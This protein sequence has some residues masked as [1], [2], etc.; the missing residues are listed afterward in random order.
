MDVDEDKVIFVKMYRFVSDGPSAYPDWSRLIQK[1]VDLE[2]TTDARKGIHGV[3][4]TERQQK[5][6]KRVGQSTIDRH[7]SLATGEAENNVEVKRLLAEAEAKLER[8]SS[9]RQTTGEGA[10][11][12]VLAP[13]SNHQ[14][15]RNQTL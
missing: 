7:Y 9:C 5:E 12:E 6:V 10:I 4:D 3:L 8:Q 2:A 1:A 13:R 11:A 14:A 15:E